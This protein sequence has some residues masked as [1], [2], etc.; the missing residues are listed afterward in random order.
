MW[1]MVCIVVVCMVMVCICTYVCVCVYHRASTIPNYL[2]LKH[3]FTQLF[4]RFLSK[5]DR[6]CLA[7]P[8]IIPIWWG[9]NCNLGSRQGTLM[10]IWRD[11]ESEEWIK[12]N[13]NNRLM[14][15]QESQT[16]NCSVIGEVMGCWRRAKVWD[17]AAYSHIHAGP[18]NKSQ[19]QCQ[20]RKRW[21]EV[22][23]VAVSPIYHTPLGR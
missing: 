2:A 14:K 8:K 16:G 15:G 17:G 20:E 5:K 10:T 21:E 11:D 4:H 9:G 23:C 1:V 19:R 13:S 18:R 7:W 12:E 22:A 6:R 3:F